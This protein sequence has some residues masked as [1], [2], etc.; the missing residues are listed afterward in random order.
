MKGRKP[1]P[2]YLHA[3]QGTARA[4]RTNLN[5]PKPR[6]LPPKHPAYL[7]LSATAKRVFRD[8]LAV[9]P[10][11]TEADFLILAKLAQAVA[12][13]GAANKRKQ[14]QAK[15]YPQ[16]GGLLS[17]GSKN[18]LVVAPEIQIMRSAEVVI[19]RISA[20]LGLTPSARSRIK[21]PTE[22]GAGDLEAFLNSGKQGK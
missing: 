6:P 1:K 4:D 10:W 17:F 15:K 2:S 16:Y 12:D 8:V 5:E 9:A 19:L 11:I 20:E 21:L 18:Q 7:A 22:D 14:E 13:W 3:V